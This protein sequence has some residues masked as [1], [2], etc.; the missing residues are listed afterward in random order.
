MA[1]PRKF[2]AKFA[3]AV[4]LSALISFFACISLI[5]A[6][7]FY[8]FWLPFLAIHYSFAAIIKYIHNREDKKRG[9]ADTLSGSFL[10]VVYLGFSTGVSIL[11]TSIVISLCSDPYCTQIRSTSTDPIIVYTILALFEYF[12]FCLFFDLCFIKYAGTRNTLY[13]LAVNFPA[14]LHT[15]TCLFSSF[16]LWLY[17]ITA[18][19]AVYYHSASSIVVYS[20][21]LLY[22]FLYL[23]SLNGLY[24]SLWTHWSF[25]HISMNL[26]MDNNYGSLLGASHPTRC[27][28][29]TSKISERESNNQYKTSQSSTIRIVQITDVHIGPL[30]SV[31]RLRQICS[32]II[33]KKPDLVLLTGDFFTGEAN[34]DGLLVKALEPLREISSQCFA[35]LG[36]G[37]HHC[38]LHLFI[39]MMDTKAIMIWKQMRYFIEQLMN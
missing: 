8:Y 32:D 21:I 11:F 20:P 38:C 22:A 5:D 27:K 28:A 30:C 1:A 13:R 7:F 2:M 26:N 15:T 12:N 39:L 9:E 29:K 16:I 25:I 10:C 35:C 14:I 17:P 4:L 31:N 34:L 33:E 3:A 23:Y 19:L 6:S 24:N 36:I 18:Y 37:V